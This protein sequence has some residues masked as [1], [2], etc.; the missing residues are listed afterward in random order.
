VDVDLIVDCRFCPQIRNTDS[1]DPD[2]QSLLT[3]RLQPA[4]PE[5]VFAR[6]TSVFYQWWHRRCYVAVL[7]DD[8][9][10]RVRGFSG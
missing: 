5:D 4:Q 2:A 8:Q 1:V 10:V 6:F 7:I 3:D 9:W